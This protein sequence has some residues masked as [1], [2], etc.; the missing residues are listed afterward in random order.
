M[1]DD[2]YFNISEMK[3]SISLLYIISDAPEYDIIWNEDSDV[4]FQRYWST[5]PGSLR[6]MVQKI[7]DCE[8]HNL[9][10]ISSVRKKS[11]LDSV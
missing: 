11:N 6:P 3:L 7:L 10:T 2:S 8:I 4:K 1:T 5:N 9:K